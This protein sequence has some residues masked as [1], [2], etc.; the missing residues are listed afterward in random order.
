MTW[1]LRDQSHRDHREFSLVVIVGAAGQH[2][3]GGGDG[4]MRGHGQGAAAQF[5]E[6]SVWWYGDSSGSKVLTEPVL[7]YDLG[8]CL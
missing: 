5:T 2:S 1:K 8:P 6:P 4:D 7:Q 3:Q